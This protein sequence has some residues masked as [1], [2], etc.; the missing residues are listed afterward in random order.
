[1]ASGTML[2]KFWPQ[3]EKLAKALCTSP[4]RQQRQSPPRAAWQS[5]TDCPPWRR[6]RPLSSHR[7]RRP[8][9]P[10]AG[11]PHDSRS[12]QTSRTH[13]D[14]QPESLTWRRVRVPAPCSWALAEPPS[15]RGSMP[16][17]ISRD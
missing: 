2:M 3:F 7:D 15:R 5:P 13:P 17:T 8:A 10:C 11:A 6:R 14:P 12:R 1:M 16:W 9:A 4:L